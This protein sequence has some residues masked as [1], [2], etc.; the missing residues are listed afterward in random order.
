MFSFDCFCMVCVCY[1]MLG[2]SRCGCTQIF[3][4]VYGLFDDFMLAYS[5]AAA[6]AVVVAH[7]TTQIQVCGL[8]SRCK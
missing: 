6:T 1:A 5:N 3:K 2:P 4:R 8:L 7:R